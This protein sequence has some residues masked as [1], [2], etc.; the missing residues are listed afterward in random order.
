MTKRDLAKLR[1]ANRLCERAAAAYSSICP[2]VALTSPVEVYN[3]CRGAAFSPVELLLAFYLDAQNILL[4][5]AT[6][7]LGSINCTRNRP[8]DILR[9]GLLHGAFGLILVHNHPSGTLEPS[10][11][12]IAFSNNMSKACETVGMQLFDHLVVTCDGYTS[13]NERGCLHG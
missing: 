11:E 4:H 6:V 2:H 1:H 3:L 7:G 12:D 8:V 10:A 9:P 13:L 5:R